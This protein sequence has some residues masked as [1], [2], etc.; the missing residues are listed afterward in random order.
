M[1]IVYAIFSLL[2]IFTALMVGVL[3]VVFA[4]VSYAVIFGSNKI[5]EPEQCTKCGSIKFDLH[6]GG[7]WDGP[8]GGGAVF[9]AKCLECEARYIL[10]DDGGDQQWRIDD[11]TTR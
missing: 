2:A 10:L 7:R 9:S 1:Q 11:L 5:M 8:S 4:T 3:F 6:G